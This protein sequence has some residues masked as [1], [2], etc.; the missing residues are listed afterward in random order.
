MLESILG[1][2]KP[3]RGEKGVSSEINTARHPLPRV[4]IV[5]MREAVSCQM[6]SSTVV[7]AISLSDTLKALQILIMATPEKRDSELTARIW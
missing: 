2:I 5:H 4:Y 6:A 1:E 3:Q 7:F